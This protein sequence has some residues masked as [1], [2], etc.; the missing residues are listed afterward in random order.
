MIL[1][2]Y[3]GQGACGSYVEPFLVRRQF[4]IIAGTATYWC[5]GTT[6]HRRS[7]IMVRRQRF[8]HL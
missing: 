4:V 2:I 3:H 7:R 6:C 5:A 8:L 1:M